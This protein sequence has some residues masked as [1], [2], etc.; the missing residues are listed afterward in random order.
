[1]FICEKII[2]RSHIEAY[3]NSEKKNDNLSF[4]WNDKENSSFSFQNT[5]SAGSNATY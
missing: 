4:I 1:M 2:V 3:Q 5:S